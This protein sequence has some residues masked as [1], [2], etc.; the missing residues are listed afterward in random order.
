M[1]IDDN[2]PKISSYLNYLP[3]VFQEGD[4]PNGDSF[5]GKF[6]YA[7]EL[8]LSGKGNGE[9]K[10]FDEII[11]EV[12]ALFDPRRDDPTEKSSEF[13]PWLANWVA[14]SLREDWD[15]NTKREFID[16]AAG[17]YRKSVV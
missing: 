6:L 8:I 5:I 7:F 12:P 1:T 3:A 2:K 10:G 4:N 15:D 16:K 9:I 14:F 13:L 17:L 11:D